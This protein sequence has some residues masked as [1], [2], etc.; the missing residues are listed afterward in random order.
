MYSEDA[1]ASPDEHWI[2]QPTQ[3]MQ[4]ACIATNFKHQTL[5]TCKQIGISSSL[6]IDNQSGRFSTET[7]WAV[8]QLLWLARLDPVHKDSTFTAV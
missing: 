3:A 7:I 8:P 6:S 1:S 2:T 4:H 5:C